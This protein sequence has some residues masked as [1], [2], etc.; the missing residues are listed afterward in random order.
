[1]KTSA[2]PVPTENEYA[3]GF[4][5]PTPV[6]V[7]EGSACFTLALFLDPEDGGDMFLTTVC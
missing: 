7:K 6:V 5:V 4:E 3:A 2:Q 1:M